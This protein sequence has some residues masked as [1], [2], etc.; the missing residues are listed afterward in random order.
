MQVRLRFI[1][2]MLLAIPWHG[3]PAPQADE[4]PPNPG[5][6]RATVVVDSSRSEVVFLAGP[7]HVPALPHDDHDEMDL[8]IPSERAPDAFSP[9]IPFTWPVDG[10]YR[11]FRIA[12]V[13]ADGRVLPRALMHLLAGVNYDRRQLLNGQVDRFLA[14]GSESPDKT[15]P[16]VLGVPMKAGHRLAIYA[17]WHNDLGRDYDGVYIRVVMNYIAANTLLKPWSAFPVYMDVNNVAGENNAFDVPAGHSERQFEF[18]LPIGG[19][20]IAVGGHLRDYGRDVRL[21]DAETGRVLARLD[22]IRDSCGHTVGMPIQKFLPFGLALRGG[23]RYRVV[24]EYDSPQTAAR[25]RGGIAM[26]VGLFIPSDASKWPALDRT[27]PEMI[28]DLESLPGGPRATG[29]VFGTMQ[30]VAP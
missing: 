6:A 24:G 19:H 14:A 25:P 5:V 28:A 13:D 22:A 16:R 26:M 27:D 10:W 20:L 21:E 4:R 12:L 23:R 1:Q 2:A 17:G 7:F 11:G 30:R 3:A 18:T 8:L 15:L 9:L 29:P